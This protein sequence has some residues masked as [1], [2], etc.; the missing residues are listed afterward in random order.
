[1][2]TKYSSL[3]CACF[4]IIALFYLPASYYMFLRIIVALGAIL[5]I[6]RSSI[7]KEYAWG[8]VF[9]II[10]ILFNPFIPIYLYQKNKWIWVDLFVAFLFLFDFYP[11]KRKEKVAHKKPTIR[12]YDR[13]RI[14]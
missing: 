11:R 6:I 9:V 14:Y 13:D 5:I 3:L 10:G 2:I 7:Q 12:T 1:M 4:L 8:A